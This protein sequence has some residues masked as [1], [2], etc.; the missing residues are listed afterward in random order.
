MKIF[1]K[2]FICRKCNFFIENFLY[3][4]FIDFLELFLRFFYFKKIFKKIFIYRTNII[5]GNIFRKL[6]FIKNFLE[7]SINR[8]FLRYFMFRIFVI[9][10]FVKKYLRNILFYLFY[11][12]FL[13]T[14]LFI[15]SFFF[16]FCFIK[17]NL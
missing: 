16:N 15:Y 8:I 12:R 5:Y 9:T 10:A 17:L 13:R 3:L 14:F 7:F 1:K 2:L 11:R 4:L 6:L